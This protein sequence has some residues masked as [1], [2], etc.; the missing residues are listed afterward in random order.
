[1]AHGRGPRFVGRAPELSALAALFADADSGRGQLVALVGE[2][3]I[4]KTRTVEELIARADVPAERVLW[5]RC[6]ESE[7]APA[8]WP[9]LQA[10]RGYVETADPAE[11]RGEVADLGP[12]L[13]RLVPGLRAL[14]PERS[15]PPAVDPAQSRFQLFDAVASFLGRVARRAPVVLVIDDLHWADPD[16]L[17]LLEFV[18]REI[19]GSRVLAIATYREAE[20]RQKPGL[21]GRIAQVSRRI[22]LHGLARDDVARFLRGS[23]LASPPPL[24][25]EL[26]RTT[27]GN[28][29][30][31]AE[32]VRVLEA[33][34]RVDASA[35]AGA[36][37]RLPDEVRA[38]IR[39][40]I[41]PLGE[42]ERR[43]LVAGAV[44][45]REFDL[46][47]LQ[48]VFDLSPDEALGR[49]S[50]ASA[51]GLVDEVPGVVGRFRFGHALIR[52]TLYG[53][54]SASERAR[55]H[56]DVGRALEA[57][58]GAS[59]EPPLSELAHHFLLAAPLGEAARAA[60]YATRAAARALALL[61]Y[62]DA[63]AH[64]ARAIDAVELRGGDPART[65]ELRLALGDAR[66]RAGD[67]AGARAAFET[68]AR[69]ARAAGDAVA[70]GRAAVGYSHATPEV[71]AVHVR[72]VE[73]LEEAL[74][75]LGPEDT[76]LRASL[77]GR[78]AAALYFSHGDEERRRALSEQAVAMARRVG[79][80]PALARALL[81][82]HFVLWGPPGGL[83]ARLAIAD[84]MLAIA[85]RVGDRALALE[86]HAWRILNR[87][88]QGDLAGF[89][90]ELDQY[91]RLCEQSRLP[92]RRWHLGVVRAARALLAGRYPEALALAAEAYA[93][94]PPAIE[95]LHGQFFAS[96][97]FFPLGE[98]GRLLELEPL[99]ALYAEKL[100][101]VKMWRCALALLHLHTG[102]T[103]LA[104]SA[105][106]ELAAD[107]FASLP[108]D[109]NF[110]IAIA[111][112]AEIAFATGATA[113]ASALYA[114]FE[115]YA[116]TCLVIGLSA[117]SFGSARRWLALLAALAGRSDEAA[118]HFERALAMNRRLD[119][120]PWLAATQL[121]YARFLLARAG[122]G[123]AERA[124]ALLAEAEQSA[125]DL[126]LG[127]LVGAIAAVRDAGRDAGPPSGTAA[128]ASR[129]AS[130]APA[131]SASGS[132]G[133]GPTVAR[134]RRAGDWWAIE[135]TREGGPLRVRD[136]KGVAYLAKLI[137]H[138]GHEFHSLDL[139]GGEAAEAAGGDAGEMLDS[140]A[141]A[142][143]RRRL[144]EL[145]ADLA[146]AVEFNDAGRIDR[147]QEE[148]EV[149]AQEL[150][151]AVGLGGRDRKAASAAERARVNVT[152]AIAKAVAEV[153]RRDAALGRSLASAVHTGLFCRYEP[154]P[155]AAVRWEA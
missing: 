22:R 60:E 58:D 117:G 132:A 20:M 151:R 127:R 7:G 21:L 72:L 62:E 143:Y 15:E 29:F 102:R 46:G 43:L 101:G 69:M 123:D 39:R 26:V 86:G 3:G 76:A 44:M 6:P 92:V 111:E 89:E 49:L 137:A 56:R 149:L 54:L 48:I 79:D 126:D 103:A 38:L 34:G 88:E 52:E 155:D 71:G 50:A 139:A 68:A 154:D 150:S 33:E 128:A 138:P 99:Y 36:P 17:L 11:L 114:L 136:T 105:L 135:T 47:V 98:A 110:A 153:T 27:D 104:R 121:D 108:R 91:A 55:F 2:A 40:R 87:L 142:A 133:A 74:A 130:P 152:R 146:E 35:L 75:T 12:E 65:L 140:Q 93:V 41:E 5:G 77:L 95:S 8:Y 64:Y 131:A 45:G 148:R 129:A 119:A 67:F 31:L 63:V 4:G 1:M 37:L 81:V 70:F 125:R 51:S 66:W 85:E 73:L 10:L 23:A 13:A 18:A 14:A 84:E 118:V 144:A 124:A 113:H 82:Q 9:W 24:V 116:D 120:R 112:L 107:G 42:A 97:L 19:R 53:D 145:E 94:L 90:L 78:L 115:P 32:V 57:R 122:S 100:P 96:Q 147:L 16:S 59:A 61:A 80:L 109:G 28:P 25:D 141:R 134:L 106:D 83:A 30:F